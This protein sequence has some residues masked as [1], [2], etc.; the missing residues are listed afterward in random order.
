MPFVRKGIWKIAP[1]NPRRGD[2]VVHQY[3][4]PEHVEA[5]MDRFFAIYNDDVAPRRYP[6]EVEAAWLHHRFVRTHPFQ[7]GNGRVSRLLMAY[8][9]VKRNL[10]S[11]I[12]AALQSLLTS[13]SWKL[14][15]AASCARSWIE[16]PCWL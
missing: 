12:I 1:N 11:P 6:V 10:P 3:C 4:P 9:Y 15:T 5:E 2:G 13:L 8:A 14:R 16:S 7:D